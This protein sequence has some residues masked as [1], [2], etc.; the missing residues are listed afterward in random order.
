MKKNLSNFYYVPLEEGVETKSFE[1][2]APG[3]FTE[4]WGRIVMFSEPD[5]VEIANRT[6]IAL[7]VKKAEEGDDFAGLPIEGAG[8]YSG[9]AVGWIKDASLSVDGKRIICYPEWND[10]GMRI[11]EKEERRY[12]SPMKALLRLS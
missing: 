12:F 3:K 2:L 11:L 6:K 10:E 4:M 9:G 1:G 5:L 8:H 7:A